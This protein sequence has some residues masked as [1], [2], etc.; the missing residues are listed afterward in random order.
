[1]SDELDLT[2][3]EVV[4]GAIDESK[5]KLRNKLD[6]ESSQGILPFTNELYYEQMNPVVRSSLFT[7]G[8]MNVKNGSHYL[9]W[10]EIFSFGG[11]SIHYRGPHLTVDH[12]VVL[13]K[14]MVLA[15]GRSLTKPIHAFQAD[16][17]RW[18]KLDAASGKNYV[19]ARRILDDLAAAEIR[20]S[21]KPALQRLLAILTSPAIAELPDG[22]F[23]QSYINNR[24][25][26]Q[27]KMIAKGL[28]DDQPVNVT[29]KL[30]TSQ[31][32]NT[33]TKRMMINLDPVF[34]IFFDGVNTTLL[35]F[36]IWDD[37][38]R[39][40]KKLLSLIS[41]HRDGVFPVMLEKIHEFSGSVSEFEKVK[42]RVKSDLKK[43]FEDWESKNYI[44]PGWNISRNDNGIEIIRG[45]KAG[46]AVRI[47]SKLNLPPIIDSDDDIERGS[48][49][50]VNQRAEDFANSF[51]APAQ[52]HGKS[53]DS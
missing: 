52:R 49:R 42:R 19:K 51:V 25:N 43:R 8:K 26:D 48:D 46:E 47:R 15:R 12:E 22:L 39:F 3:H 27:L 35:P 17:L 7:A 24:F 31:T 53:T 33:V 28:A 4:R 38:D 1:M 37:L 11:G 40:G 41:S 29:M 50:V 16:L 10:T 23:F 32:H 18:L 5:S 14:L 36:E 9:E 30:V 2:P 45:L 6:L 44:V 13:V 20:I 21:S 34:A